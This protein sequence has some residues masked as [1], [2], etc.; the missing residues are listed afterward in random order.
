[1]TEEVLFYLGAHHT[2]WLATAGVP[3]FVSRR[4]LQDRKS[5]PRATTR[6]ALDSGGFS[7]LTLHGK[8]T[9][10]PEEYVEQVRTYSDKIGM[11]DWAAVMDYMCE[12]QIINGDAKTVG[13]GLSVPEHQRRTVQS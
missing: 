11:L 6:W 8:W 7:E 10:T 5:F 4:R 9:I 13:T 1:M 3:L 2:N 12:P